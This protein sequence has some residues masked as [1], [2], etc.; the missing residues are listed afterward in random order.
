MKNKTKNQ[1]YTA[2][3]LVDSAQQDV[4]KAINN[5]RGWWS[6]NIRGKTDKLNAVW[7]YQYKD[8]HLCKIKIIELVPNKKVVWHVLENYFN[9]TTDENEW[10]GNKIIFEISRKGKKRNSY[11][12]MTD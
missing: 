12:H 10:K 7:R 9:F 6:E 3:I 1:N 5:V 11:L 8:V 2:T 4:Y